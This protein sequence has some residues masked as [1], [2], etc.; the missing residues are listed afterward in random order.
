MSDATTSPVS[1]RRAAGPHGI[2]VIAWVVA[3]MCL[4]PMVAVALAAVLGG[5]DTV[6]HL[7]ETVLGRYAANTALLVVLV[8]MGTFAVGVGA[9]WLVTMTRFP[10]VR[11]LEIAPVLP[12]AFPAYVLAY[13]YTDLL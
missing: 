8:A 6:G 2:A 9:A 4:L 11:L 7:L 12:L 3:C 13:A 5:T 1:A 10:G